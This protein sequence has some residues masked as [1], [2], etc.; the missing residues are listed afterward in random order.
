MRKVLVFAVLVSGCAAELGCPDCD[1]GEDAKRRRRPDLS[2]P[3]DLS[4]LP[5]LSQP[6]APS[7]DL[8]QPAAPSADLSQPPAQPDL[9]KAPD[10]AQP[11]TPPATTAPVIAGCQIFPADNPW[12]TDISTAQVDPNSANYMTHMNAS[13]TLLHPDFGSNPAYGIPFI[14]VPGT[15][16]KVP[17]S[18]DYD[19]DSDPGPYPFPSNAPIEGGAGASGDRHILVLDRD[20]CLLYETWDSHYVGPG[21]HCGSGAIFNLKSNA[22]RPDGYTSADAAGLPILPGLIRY[23][24][25]AAGEIRHALRFTVD[26]TQ[27]AYVHPATHFAS[28]DTSANAPPM[29][30]RVRLKASYNISNF[31]GQSRVIL[32]A[33]KKYGMFLADN[34]SDWYFTGAADSRWDD[35]DLEQL[36]NVPASAFEVVKLGT[37]I[38]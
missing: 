2:A 16:T 8:S 33:M 21:F 3:P 1:G 18:F 38:K 5:D 6:A 30:L 32:T 26:S 36:K 12:N 29:G 34:G 35:D 17:M 9:A 11:S 15:Q 24:E 28:S 37:I 23:D 13:S 27:R 25:V 10:L 31:T 20:N 19:E 7:A 22:L 14:T 4:Q